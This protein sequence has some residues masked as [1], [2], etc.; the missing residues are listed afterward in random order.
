MNTKIEK[1]DLNHKLRQHS[2]GEELYNLITPHL[3]GLTDEITQYFELFILSIGLTI[4]HQIYATI[5]FQRNLLI[6]E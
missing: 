4:L 2:F 5:L 3:Q 1:Q 6:W